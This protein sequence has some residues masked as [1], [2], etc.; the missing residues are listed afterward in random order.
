[1]QQTFV[2]GATMATSASDYSLLLSTA[3]T[4]PETV[5]MVVARGRAD[6]VILMETLV[7]GARVER[8]ATRSRLASR[9]SPGSDIRGSRYS[10]SRPT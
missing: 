5:A 6:G 4:D 3:A 8:L 1:V 9:V 10:T 7:H 2:T